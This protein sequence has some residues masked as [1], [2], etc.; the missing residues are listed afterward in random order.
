MPERAQS[1]SY[2]IGLWAF[3]SLDGVTPATG[4]TIALQ[5]SKNGGA[6]G[7]PSGGATNLTEVSNGYYTYV[8]TTT[9]T[10][11][12]G[13]LA[14]LGT[15]S[16]VDNLI[17]NDV[18]VKATNRGMTALPDTP[19]TTNASLLTSGTGTD[20]LSVSGGKALLQNAS[21]S[22]STY[23]SD[24]IQLLTRRA[25][26]SGVTVPVTAD[27][28]KLAGFYND[29]VY[30]ISTTLGTPNYIWWDGTH[31]N[32]TTTTP[33]S[34]P[35]NYF[36]AT[37][38]NGTWTGVGTTTGTPAAVAHGNSVLAAFQPDQTLLSAA[39]VAT[40]PTTGTIAR[41]SDVTSATSTLASDI[42]S[43]E[44]ALSSAITN[45]VTTLAADI[46]TA[47]GIVEVASFSD[48]ALAQLSA[49]TIVV[50]NP[51]NV[52]SDQGTIELVAGDDYLV[53]IGRS[54]DITLT[55]PSLPDMT[56]SSHAYLALTSAKRVT[57]VYEVTIHS[58]SSSQIVLRIELTAAQTSP[59]EE[60]EGSWQPQFRTA[61]GY[62]WTVAGD[63]VL[64]VDRKAS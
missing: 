44:T 64:I 7:N 41:A 51:A 4:K 26:F 33:G 12:L 50:Q 63:W 39:Q 35:A 43:S 29:A 6:F 62:E 9:D 30:Y 16:G 36:Q 45:A 1:T 37:S 18:I 52:D 17:W 54:F 27:T 40:I 56:G 57:R 60:G 14:F 3:L 8:V 24:M 58:S 47:A 10:N 22:P 53:S 2:T 25:T 20:Q 48:G 15:C 28:Y 46:M 5:I 31:W 42:A 32:L 13:P 23:T 11:T 55:G 59:L 49:Q 38:V 34:L 61:A 19:N 21:I